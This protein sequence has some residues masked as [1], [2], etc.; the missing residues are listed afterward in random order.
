HQKPSVPIFV[1]L[2]FAKLVQGFHTVFK[3]CIQNLVKAITRNV[4]FERRKTSF[5]QLFYFFSC[6]FFLAVSSR[7]NMVHARMF[8]K[9]Q[10]EHG[11]WIFNYK[12]SLLNLVF[13]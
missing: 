10:V 2:Y 4:H 1:P 11:Q 8:W 5:A 6:I 7:N 12:S 13:D 9:L 3:T